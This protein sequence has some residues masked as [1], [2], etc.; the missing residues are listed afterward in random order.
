[1]TESAGSKMNSQEKESIEYQCEKL[2]GIAHVNIE[3]SYGKERRFLAGFD[4]DRAADCGI[5]RSPFSGS[6]NYT[7]DCPLHIALENNLN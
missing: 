7:V 1:M 6:L 4:C 3:Y 2:G 5:R